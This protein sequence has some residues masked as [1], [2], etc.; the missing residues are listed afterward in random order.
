MHSHPS[1]RL[2]RVALVAACIG[3]L[4]AAACRKAATPA[5]PPPEV[6]VVTVRPTTVEDDVLFTGQ[7]Q[8][9]RTVQVRAQVSGVIVART[10][11]EGTEVRA[12]DVLYRIDPT[13]SEADVRSARARLADCLLYTSPS[14]R[15]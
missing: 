11:T 13:T 8:A 3:S 9:F 2:P 1:P 5:P 15:D 4:G 14:P 10:F 12:G 6:S 7:V